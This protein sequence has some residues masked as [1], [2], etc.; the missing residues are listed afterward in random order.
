MTFDEN[1]KASTASPGSINRHLLRAAK[2][3]NTWL[4]GTVCAAVGGVLLM[5]MTYASMLRGLPYPGH[6]LNLL[7]V[8]LPGYSVSPAGAW[9][10]LVWGGLVGG[11]LG[12]LLYRIY[13]RSIEAQVMDYLKNARSKADL[14]SAKF[15]IDGNALGLAMGAVV[16]GG[17]LVTT[18]WLVLR[19]TADESVHA[20]LL[21]SYLPGYSV[22]VVGSVIG[23]VQLFAL[24]YLV[25]R[26]FAWIYNTV[27]T[28]RGGK[29]Q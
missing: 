14:L 6:Y 4:F 28:K 2:K 1:S 18:N 21:S 5:G 20:S 22:S 29:R 27:T 23:A 16:A 7:G 26:L 9:I 3:L 12:A 11:A 10:G 13:A 15:W 17:L 24:M 25:C 8:F 19:G